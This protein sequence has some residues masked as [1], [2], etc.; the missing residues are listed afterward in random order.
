[1]HPIINYIYNTSPVTIQNL[2]IS[3]YGIDLY[4]KRYQGVH[5]EYLEFLR[6]SQGYSRY[7]IE[8]MKLE[9]LSN[10]LKYVYKNVPFYQNFFDKR[11]FKPEDIKNEE[12]LRKLPIVTKDDLRKN[13]ELFISNEFKSNE[14]ISIHTSGTTGTPLTFYFKKEA[15]QKNY[16]FFARFLGWAGVKI[17]DKSATFA[18]R[19]F[20]PKSQI[21]PP[22][23]RT[24]WIMNNTLFSSY[25]ISERNIPLYI[26][27]LEELNPVF[28]DSYPSAIYVIARHVLENCIEHK[29]NPKAIITSSETLLEHQRDVIEKAFNCKVYDQYGSAEMVVFISQCEK[30][31]YHIN[32]EYGIVELINNKG[33]AVKTGE[34]GELICTGFLNYA[35]PLIRYKIGDS[36]ILSHESCSCNR[37]FPIIKSILGRVDDLIITKDGRMVGRLDPIF[38]GSSSIK[39]TQIIQ[40]N[41]D[42]ILLK[43]VKGV[44]FSSAVVDDLIKEL[45]KRVGYDMIIKAEFVDEIPRSETGKFRSVISKVSQ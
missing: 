38:K 39:E 20:I 13:P 17:G 45:Q 1:M 40:E 30:G 35:M 31:S 36:A 22:F 21:D 28:I 4:K 18:G 24:N 9:S 12:N 2:M 41:I 33:E 32:P 34:P 42:T 11:G 27:K 25:H 15:V 10:L 3:L 43:I 5:R 44:D 23:W 26:K 6:K 8:N 29:I 37:N 16:A 14:L 7:Q 19:V